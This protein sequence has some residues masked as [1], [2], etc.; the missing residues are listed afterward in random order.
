MLYHSRRPDLMIILFSAQSPF[1]IFVLLAKLHCF[2]DIS[3]KHDPE[4]VLHSRN[5]H[6]CSVLPRNI[7]RHVE[8]HATLSVHIIRDGCRKAQGK[9]VSKLLWMLDDLWVMAISI[10]ISI[11]GELSLSCP[12]KSLYTSSS[13]STFTSCVSYFN[14]FFSLKMQSAYL[15]LSAD[16]LSLK[17][18]RLRRQSSTKTPAVTRSTFHDVITLKWRILVEAIL[19]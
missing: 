9:K 1:D 7:L 2:I 11:V 12:P 16:S 8:V 5:T 19:V 13:S 15:P 17:I 3:S 4:C 10:Y 18:V 6:P 14:A